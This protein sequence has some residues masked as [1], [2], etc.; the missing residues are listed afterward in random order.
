MPSIPAMGDSSNL[1]LQQ[2][3]GYIREN[4]G[5][6]PKQAMD[7]LKIKTLSGVNLR[8]AVEQLQKIVNNESATQAEQRGHE[9]VSTA[10][11]PVRQNSGPLA[12]TPSK[13]FEPSRTSSR[14]VGE[15]EPLYAFNEEV[16]PDEDRED[17]LEDLDFPT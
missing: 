15:E 10:P 7:L 3:I 4:M 8:E 6:N 12:A 13:Q 2:F 5:L 16:E 14:S 1:S 11:S 9:T 17:D